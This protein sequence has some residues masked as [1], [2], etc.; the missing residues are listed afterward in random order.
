MLVQS[1][2]EDSAARFPEKTALI[3]GGERLSYAE[4]DARANRLAHGLIALGL[5]RGD[6]VAVWLD[7]SVETAVSLWA[8]LKAGGVFMLL[9]PTLK[10]AKLGYVLNDSRA[11]MLVTDAEKLGRV[12]EDWSALPHLE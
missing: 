9:N 11:R 10:T 3:A 6:R 2:L 7:N 5:E 4:L 1:F 12:A 8:A